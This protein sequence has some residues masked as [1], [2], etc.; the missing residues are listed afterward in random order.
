MIGASLQIL[1]VQGTGID[2]TELAL[3]IPSLDVNLEQE[4]SVP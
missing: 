2:E 4:V 3:H 1:G